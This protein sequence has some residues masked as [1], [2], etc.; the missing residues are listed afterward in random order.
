MKRS[1]KITLCLLT[2]LGSSSI[3]NAAT[4]QR[5]SLNDIERT[6]RLLELRQKQDYINQQLMYP[7]R[8]KPKVEKDVLDNIEEGKKYLF[9]NIQLVGSN[10]LKKETDKIIKEYINTEMGKEDIYNLL[11]KLSNVFLV[12]GYSTTL[13]TLKS[14]NVN[15]GE[16]IYEVKEGKVRDIKFMD[17]QEG[18]RDRLKIKTAFPMKKGELLNTRDMDQGIENMN[19]GGNNNVAEIVPTDEYGYSD[20]MIEENYTPTGFSIGMDNSSYKDKGRN[21]VNIGFSQDNILGIN[22]VLTLNYIERLTKDREKDKESNYDIGLAFPIGYWK[23]SYNYNLGDNYNTYTSDIGSYKTESRTEKHKLKLSRVI[24]RGQYQK[25]TIHTGLTVR[26]NK[27]TL[28]GLLLEVNSKKYANTSIA[29]DHTNRFLGGTIFG[30]LEYERGVPWLGAEGD[31]RPL[32]EGDYKIEYDKINFNL[33]WLRYFNIKEHNFQYRLG[34]GGSYSDDR[35]LAVNQFTMGDE[36]TVRGF[37]ESSV[38]GNKGVYLNNTLT[39]LG[40]KNT[41][42]YLSMFKPFIGLD[43]GASRD[44]DLPN[45]DKIVGMALGVRFDIGH[46]NGSLTYGIPLKWAE[47]MPH[48]KNPIYFNIS[49]SF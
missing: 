43:A 27:N 37:K 14:G 48:E 34:I 16:L 10:K 38:A 17:K 35:L 33:D 45:S 4:V 12:K 18:F 8:N 39:Y 13:V 22:D 15:K 29:I 11:I 23:I 46:I 5:D 21:K 9:T 49:Y 32:K 30:A 26:D 31:P 25:T 3:L 1:W 7:N 2:L 47:G 19:V 40:G 20:I 42:E 44:R 28:N 41:N 24:S 36:Y 6:Q